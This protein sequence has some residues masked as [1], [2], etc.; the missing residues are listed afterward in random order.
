MT[1]SPLTRPGDTQGNSPV[2][3]QQPALAGSVS[4]DAYGAG[5]DGD[6]NVSASR[7]A[8]YDKI[9][10]I[11]GNV[12]GP[13]S[14]VNL[15]LVIFDSTTGKL[16]KGGSGIT[17]SASGTLKGVTTFTDANGNELLRFLATA[18]AVNEIEIRN[19]IA[20]FAPQIASTGDDLNIDVNIAPKGTGR[21]QVNA[22]NVPTISSTDTLTNKTIAPANLTPSG[23]T[24]SRIIYV[25]S[26]TATD[27]FPICYVGDAVT[28]IAI[29]SVRKSVV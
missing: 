7:N 25:E 13:A 12:V 6:T 3:L 15:E 1:S 10:T 19:I 4:D 22:V 24:V 21:L 5:W 2:T 14:A 9:Q 16:I 20:G 8:L 29:R 23:K 11:L 26:P 27:E 17:N 18:S 28:I